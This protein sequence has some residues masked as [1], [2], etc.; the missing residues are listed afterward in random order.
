MDNAQHN[1]SLRSLRLADQFFLFELPLNQHHA[2][3]C[4]ASLIQASEQLTTV[5]LWMS[6]W[7]RR[8]LGP[9]HA[10]AKMR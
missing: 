3:A 9:A 5:K 6:D 4:P 1:Y 2:A 7:T 8:F 10:R